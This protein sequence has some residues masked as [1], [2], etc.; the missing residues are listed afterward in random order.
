MGALAHSAINQYREYIG[1]GV[2]VEIGLSIPGKNSS[3]QWF[4][5]YFDQEGIEYH[6]IEIVK[7]ICDKCEKA[8][9][10]KPM[11]NIHN[12][13]W[14]VVFDKLPKKI[15]RL[16]CMLNVVPHSQTRTRLHITWSMRS[17]CMNVHTN[18]V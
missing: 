12:E 1:D 13:D 18:V 8:W 14:K 5:N 2:A 9:G 7:D 17:G 15:V 6:G 4:A 16:Q 10:D 3:T 11:V